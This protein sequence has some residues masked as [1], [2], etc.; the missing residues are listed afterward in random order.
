MQLSISLGAVV[1]HKTNENIYDCIKKAEEKVY[2]HKLLDSK[3]IKSSIMDSLLKSLEKNLETREHSQ[4]VTRYALALGKK[5]DFKISELDELI[6]VATLH[7]IGKIGICE[8]ILLK[9]GSLTND[10][11]EIM[12]NSYRKRISHYKCI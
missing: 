12:K 8:D 10:E 1:K 5:L 6:L 11:F 9:T 3:S 4:R 2:R 7:D